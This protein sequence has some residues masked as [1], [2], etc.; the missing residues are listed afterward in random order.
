[1][2]PKELERLRQLLLRR[3]EDILNASMHN[4]EAAVEFGADGPP[5]PG[6]EGSTSYNRMVLV[7]LSEAEKRQIVEIDDALARIKNGTYGTCQS[8]GG[9]IGDK[10]L[11]V[12]P[13]APYCVDCQNS[14]EG[15]R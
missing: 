11:S 5:D 12:K 8:C 14:V 4:R 3:R 6:D 13:E 2:D 7:S 1:M 10:R 15:K 9:A